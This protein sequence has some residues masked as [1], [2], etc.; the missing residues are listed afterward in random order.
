MRPIAIRLWLLF[1][2]ALS[3]SST[4]IAAHANEAYMIS[5]ARQ[6]GVR[7]IVMDPR[8]IELA[9]R[10]D[11][12]VCVRPGT[13]CALA[14]GL[15]NVIIAEELYDKAFVKDWTIG[16]EELAAELQKTRRR[17]NALEYILVPDLE[18]TIKFISTRLSEMERETT[19]RLMKIKDIVREH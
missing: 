4:T 5:E 6:R 7:L 18:K 11:L 8:K 14:L 2:A 19:T 10:A 16:F 9:K 12:Y 13:D 3:L 17:V 15:I 1:L